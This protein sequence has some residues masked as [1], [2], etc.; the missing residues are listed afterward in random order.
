MKVAFYRTVHHFFPN[1]TT[2]LKAIKDPRQEKSTTYSLATLVWV[3]ILLFVLKLESRRQI[4]F[5]FNSPKFIKN[6]SF[7]T[8]Q[9]LVRICDDDTLAN[10]LVL[11][12]P[13]RFYDLRVKMVN[14]LLRRKCLVKY[15]LYDYYLITIDGTGYL[16]FERRHCPHCLIKRKK[17]RVKY[18][19][20]PVVEA[21]LVTANGLALSIETEFIENPRPGVKRQDCEVK[22]FYRLAE[23]LAQRFPQLRICLLLDALYAKERVLDICKENKWRYI[24]TFKRGSLPETYQEYESLK[25]LCLKNVGEYYDRHRAEQQYYHWVNDIN[26]KLADRHFLNVLECRAMSKKR[27]ETTCYLWLTNFEINQEN[28]HYLANK[29][30]RLRWKTENEG[31]NMQKN[32]GYNLEHAYSYNSVAMKNF[33]LLMQIAHILNQLIEKGSLLTDTIKKSLGSIRNIAK[34]LLEDLRTSLFDT[35]EIATA[36]AKRFQIRFDTS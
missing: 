7:L 32:G 11:I 1:F 15:R 18:Y 4:N 30:G 36:L 17:G 21:K 12:D 26:Y 23:R 34:R 16:S 3:G 6:L 10:L 33:Y 24:I 20:H 19:Y 25:K 31:F 9:K 28:F 2:W 14:Q 8:K 22:A 29:G 13:D 27:K 5:A 35:N